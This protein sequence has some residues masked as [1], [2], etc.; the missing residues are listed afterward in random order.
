MKSYASPRARCFWAPSTLSEI[1][2]IHIAVYVSTLRPK[3]PAAASYSYIPGNLVF[4]N[5]ASVRKVPE[6][7]VQGTGIPVLLYTRY[8][9]TNHVVPRRC[10]FP[11]AVLQQ[12]QRTPLGDVL[13]NRNAL[14]RTSRAGLERKTG[15]TT[16]EADGQERE[17][18]SASARRKRWLIRHSSVNTTRTITVG[19]TALTWL[20]VRVEVCAPWPRHGPRARS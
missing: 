6:K 18:P 4:M 16:D 11:Q 5:T 2:L 7:L 15:W 13:E 12:E 10:R 19:L 20:P 17:M 3:R 8:T 14:R 9:S 1:P